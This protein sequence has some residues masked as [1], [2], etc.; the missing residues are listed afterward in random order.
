MDEGQIIQNQRLQRLLTDGG[1]LI[2]R[3]QAEGIKQPTINL[4]NQRWCYPA[5]DERMHLA[6]SSRRYILERE[7]LIE[8]EGTPLVFARTVFPAQTLTGKEKMLGKLGTRSL[9][10]VLFN[11]PNLQRSEFEFTC[12]QPYMKLYQ[13]MSQYTKMDNLSLWARCSLF[14]IQHKSLLL[15]EVFLPQLIEKITHLRPTV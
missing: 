15:T 14:F 4:L 3:L 1:S 10:S 6:I 11:K 7:V 2:K 8:S 9:G 5:Q 12:L 13:R